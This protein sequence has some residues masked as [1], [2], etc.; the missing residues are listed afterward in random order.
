MRIQTMVMR[1]L[2]LSFIL[3]GSLSI[4][5]QTAV[6][7]FIDYQKSFPKIS[8][9]L[10]RKEDLLVKEFAAKGLTWPAKQVYIRSFKYD[11][12]LEVWVRNDRADSF[13]LFKT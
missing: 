7:N 8:D 12:Q 5:A 3:P 10:S 13:V 2:L 4:H 6:S 1:T 11:S 9:V